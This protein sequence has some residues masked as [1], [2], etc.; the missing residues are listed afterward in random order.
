MQKAMRKHFDPFALS[1]CSSHSIA[2]VFVDVPEVFVKAFRDEGA[3][4]CLPSGARMHVLSC[5]SESSQD[6]EALVSVIERFSF[7]VILFVAADQNSSR[8]FVEN[9]SQQ[10]ERSWRSRLHWTVVGHRQ[11]K[12]PPNIPGISEILPP[13]CIKSHGTLAPA[14][15]AK[16]GWTLA[17]DLM[18][19]VSLN[20]QMPMGLSDLALSTAESGNAFFTKADVADT[21]SN[22]VVVALDAA[23]RNARLEKRGVL[24][25]SIKGFVVKV[26][27]DASLKGR[28]VGAASRYLAQKYPQATI[29]F[30]VERKF[31]H[32]LVEIAARSV[33]QV[34]VLLTGQG[35]NKNFY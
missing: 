20:N 18:D 28:D 31:S 35:T 29:C 4:K 12:F 7:P 3:A 21:S 15:L 16:C 26:S 19:F 14:A 11:T 17:T 5:A 1:R 9:V 6:K 33:T 30:C 27:A 34:T 2:I 8:T 10:T 22:R 25:S 24:S 32:C 23:L 13:F